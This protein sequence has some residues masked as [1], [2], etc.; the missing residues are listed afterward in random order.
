LPITGKIIGIDR[1]GKKKDRIGF[2][3]AEEL[4]GG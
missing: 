4:N 1:L 2:I 3:V